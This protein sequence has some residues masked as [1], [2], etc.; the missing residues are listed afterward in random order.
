MTCR[1]KYQI[2]ARTHQLFWLQALVKHQ[3]SGPTSWTPE[4]I[5]C[6]EQQ[7]LKM[8]VGFFVFFLII[9]DTTQVTAEMNQ[10]TKLKAAK[11]TSVY[12]EEDTAFFLSWF[13][14]EGCLCLTQ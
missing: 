6:Q 12:L 10:S 8:A 5:L 2:S 9:V 11:N 3:V 13:R 1:S 7:A 4:L 14:K